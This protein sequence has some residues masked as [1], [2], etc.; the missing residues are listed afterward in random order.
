VQFPFVRARLARGA[1]KGGVSVNRS[2]DQG[3]GEVG[4]GVRLEREE[5]LSERRVTLW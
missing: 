4:V 5:R 1:Q 3:T 2:R